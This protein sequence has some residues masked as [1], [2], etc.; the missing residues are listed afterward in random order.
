MAEL[1]S[2]NKRLEACTEVFKKEVEET[3]N[4]LKKRFNDSLKKLNDFEK[5]NGTCIQELQEIEQ[6]MRSDKQ[7]YAFFF[8][9]NLKE[10]FP[11]NL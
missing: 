1:D 10:K 11:K 3:L 5:Q 2:D 7:S 6:K 8:L 4:I 9:N